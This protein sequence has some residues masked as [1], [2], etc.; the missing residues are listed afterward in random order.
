MVLDEL[1]RALGQQQVDRVPHVAALE[2]IR[3]DIEEISVRC[4]EPWSSAY[5]G[6]RFGRRVREGRAL[7]QLLGYTAMSQARPL[8][9]A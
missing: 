6:R 4:R 9:A 7:G 1:A 2:Q 5:R 8:A 3:H